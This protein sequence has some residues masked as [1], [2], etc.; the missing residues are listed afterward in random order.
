MADGIEQGADAFEGEVFALDRHEDVVGGNQRIDGKQVER[1]WAVNQ[2][3][4]ETLRPAE[5]VFFQQGMAHIF[6]KERFVR[7]GEVGIGGHQPDVRVFAIDTG[8]FDAA[9]AEHDVHH[10]VL[11]AAPLH[12]AGDGRICLR[13][14]VYQQH[15]GTAFGED[16]GEADGGRRFADAAFLVGDGDD[17]AHARSR[18]M[19]SRVR[20]PA[21]SGTVSG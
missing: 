17:V 12:P 14:H 8:V 11:N 21:S 6:L 1:R 2:H 4:V 16:G 18:R 15:V 10:A 3:P 19:S 9:R 5:D 20:S 7:A 13:V